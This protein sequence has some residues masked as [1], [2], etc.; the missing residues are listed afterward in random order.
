MSALTQQRE[1]E[2]QLR[3]EQQKAAHQAASLGL[4]DPSIA[5]LA[6]STNPY[7]TLGE[8]GE[9]EYTDSEGSSDDEEVGISSSLRLH[10]KSLREVISKSDVIVQVL[11]ARDPEGTR[12]RKIE[13][14]AVQV[15]GKKLVLVLNKIGGCSWPSTRR[16]S[17]RIQGRV[18]R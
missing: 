4:P 5:A 11:D 9:E 1:L 18:V 16:A 3:R 2:K 15:H 13:R 6:A 8:D 7:A 10:A 12:S 17:C 14:E